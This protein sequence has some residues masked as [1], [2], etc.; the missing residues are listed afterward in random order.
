MFSADDK[1]AVQINGEEGIYIVQDDGSIKAES[2]LY[3]SD[4][5]EHTVTAWY[6]AGD[7][8]LDLSD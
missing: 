5:G 6:P 8:P 1:F 2:P 4:S 7:G 3:W